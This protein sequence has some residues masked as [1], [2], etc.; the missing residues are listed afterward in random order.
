MG[1]QEPCGPQQEHMPSPT[2]GKDMPLTGAHRELGH[3]LLGPEQLHGQG[4]GASQTVSGAGAAAVAGSSRAE[5]TGTSR[6][7]TGS[8][9][10]L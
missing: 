10:P 1:Q 6:A 8:D 9:G 3:S 5:W 2:Q 4:L 7:M